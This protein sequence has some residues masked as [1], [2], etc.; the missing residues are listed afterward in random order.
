MIVQWIQFVNNFLSTEPLAICNLTGMQECSC[1]Y[2]LSPCLCCHNYGY[3]LTGHKHSSLME[4]HQ[5]YD[6]FSKYIKSSHSVPEGII[7]AQ[8]GVNMDIF[9]ITEIKNRGFS[10]DTDLRDFILLMKDVTLSKFPLSERRATLLT[11][12]KLPRTQ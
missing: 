3:C 10:T 4:T 7:Y 2:R 6:Q 8:A 9:W 11:Q 5:F 1:T 12:N